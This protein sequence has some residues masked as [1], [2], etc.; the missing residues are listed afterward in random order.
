MGGRGTFAAGKAA[1]FQYETAGTIEG[2]KVLRP[3]DREKSYKLPEESHTARNSYVLLDKDGVFHQY[4]EYDGNHQ[5]VLE[6]GYHPEK[7]LGKGNVLHIHIHRKPGID[8]HAD[9]ST[10]KRKLTRSEYQKYKRLFRGV[11][12]NEREYFAGIYG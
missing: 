2:V 4:R 11:T 5:V 10:E 9:P 7:A 8:F 1:A 6:I 12:L 3:I